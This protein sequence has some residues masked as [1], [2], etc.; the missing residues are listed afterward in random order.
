MV[1]VCV[2]VYVVY[3]RSTKPSSRPPQKNSSGT[4]VQSFK[5]VLQAVV[6]PLGLV[7]RIEKM[8][9]GRVKRRHRSRRKKHPEQDNARET[10][11]NQNQQPPAESQAFFSKLKLKFITAANEIEEIPA[12]PKG[13][14]EIAF[15]GR[16]NVGK[17]SLLNRVTRS[18]QY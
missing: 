11:S 5:R 2:C 16:S 3:A 15:C 14:P 13:I 8:G 17:S 7:K 4:P 9:L 10:A 18:V 6:P 1:C 12:A